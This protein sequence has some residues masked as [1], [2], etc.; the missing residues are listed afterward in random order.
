VDMLIRGGVYVSL[1][2][3]PYSLLFSS[4]SSYVVDSKSSKSVVR[5][6]HGDTDGS[7]QPNE[8]LDQ[9]HLTIKSFNNSHMAGGHQNLDISPL[10]MLDISEAYIRGQ[11]NESKAS[12]NTPISATGSNLTNT[13]TSVQRYNSLMDSAPQVQCGPG[14]P[15][16]DGS[17]CNNAGKC[18]FSP[19]H[20][21]EG[22][23]L[24]NCDAK[25]QCGRYSADGHTKCG[26]NICCSY[27]G[28]C[29]V[30][31]PHCYDPE[32]QFGKTPCQQG[33]GS[34]SIA[35][36]PHCGKDSNTATK[37]RIGYYQ[38]WNYRT[39]PCDK[40]MPAQINTKGL[41]HLYY[42]FI[43]FDPDT[44]QVKL[45]DDKDEPLLSQFT[46]LKKDG[47]E[48]W[49]AIGGWEFNDPDVAPHGFSHMVSSQQ[50]RAAF[51]NSLVPFMDKYGFQGADIDW[52]YPGDK[53]RGG[54]PEDTLNLSL[55]I[56]ELRVAF[57]NHPR[58]L[59]LSM[60]IAPD[61]EYLRHFDVKSMEPL[62]DW[63][64]FMGYDLAGAWDL[65]NPA[66]G[67]K[68]RAHTD[69]TLVEKGMRPLDFAGVNPAK[70]NLGL[71]YYGR[72]YRVGQNAFCQTPYICDYVDYGDAV[73]C[74]NSKGVISNL[75][76]RRLT[77]QGSFET[78]INETGMFRWVGGL[79]GF[80]AFQYDDHVTFQMKLGYANDRC[81]GGTSIWAVDY[82][83]D[84]GGDYTVAPKNPG[85]VVGPG[86]GGSPSTSI[87]PPTPT[88]TGKP[89][90]CQ[91]SGGPILK[92][93]V[94]TDKNKCIPQGR[95]QW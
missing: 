93:W 54:R 64:G 79:N 92:P 40:I 36:R 34:C 15:C 11:V 19:D 89:P 78:K 37:R 23:C 38:S 53:D 50:N 31:E 10:P 39:R 21:G 43:Y 63:F 55:L 52:E 3:L 26:L 59:G 49:V 82:D 60:A 30:N 33:F 28:W 25:A 44:F 74:T 72:S 35:P 83:P 85:D 13:S 51:I 56:L 67:G 45:M 20:C 84:V 7:P 48:T 17:C 68:I 9:T 4:S 95:G 8:G 87:S 57:N 88:S 42:A 47:L 80:T 58:R 5:S 94:Q 61:Y 32:P 77:T 12:V 81:L 27:Y 24:S 22:I 71:A 18:G 76:I 29:G 70:I 14:S 62:V 6:I 69:I 65:K 2:L 46:A 86:G 1:S 73:K 41:T 75:E 91:A 16:A 66:L 90:A